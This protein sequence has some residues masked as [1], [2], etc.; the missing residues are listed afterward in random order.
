MITDHLVG[1][2]WAGLAPRAREGHD[3]CDWIIESLIH[4]LVNERTKVVALQCPLGNSDIACPHRRQ[5]HEAQALA[6][7]GITPAEWEATR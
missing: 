2:V 3:A 4:K 5:E 6:S 7:Y 1:E